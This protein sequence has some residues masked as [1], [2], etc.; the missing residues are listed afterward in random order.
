M[1]GKGRLGW[2]GESCRVGD[3]GEEGSDRSTLH[4]E[5]VSDAMFSASWSKGFS[6]LKVSIGL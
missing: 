3:S 5:D 2:V 1:D 6:S 4:V